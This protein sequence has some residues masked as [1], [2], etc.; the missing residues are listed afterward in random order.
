LDARKQVNRRDAIARILALGAGGIG[1]VA[2][3]AGISAERGPGF[4]TRNETDPLAVLRSP[5][6]TQILQALT[7]IL[8]L[9]SQA[10]GLASRPV[11]EFVSPSGLR[12]FRFFAG[13]SGSGSFMTLARQSTDTSSLVFFIIETGPTFG[14]PFS[15]G[16]A[17]MTYDPTGILGHGTDA[18]IIGDD[19]TV[20]G[21]S[22][23]RVVGLADSGG[24]W[25]LSSV[26]LL[27]PGPPGIDSIGSSSSGSLK[28]AARPDHSH[29]MN[30]STFGVPSQVGLAGSRGTSTNVPRFDHVHGA[31]LG[32]LVLINA[33]ETQISGTV[34]N[35]DTVVKTYTLAANT[36]SKIIVE[37][38]GFGQFVLASTN[39]TINI[40]VKF[41]GTQVGQTMRLNAALG[42][43]SL[44]PF[45]IKASGA[46]AA[47]GAVDVTIG[48]LNADTNTI[49][50][51]NSL[52]V[53]GVV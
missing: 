3:G 37:A 50:F 46:F 11:Y 38:E 47:G 6:T 26:L 42:A 40:K 5:S 1:V 29:S 25:D 52:R 12:G 45:P 34:P 17:V 53:Y 19:G 30:T 28:G 2:L 43:T 8:P 32:T 23:A 51:L 49:L 41:A 21:V 39:Q 33:D 16:K 10:T 31:I 44:I 48:A 14:G 22:I 20:A 13:D 15:A 18:L 4:V 36:Y 7:D 9:R 27:N 24:G 35:A